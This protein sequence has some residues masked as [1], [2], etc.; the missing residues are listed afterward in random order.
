VS[1]WVYERLAEVPPEEVELPRR[2]RQ[3]MNLRWLAIVSVVAIVVFTR[4]ALGIGYPLGPVV[5]RRVE[6]LLVKHNTQHVM[7]NNH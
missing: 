6:K 2:L 3:Y 5:L 4:G 7:R 1:D